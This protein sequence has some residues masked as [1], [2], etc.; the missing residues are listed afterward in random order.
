MSMGPIR[1][2]G[3][4]TTA[5]GPCR[6]GC[7]TDE[8]WRL[9][10]L[11]RT[12]RTLIDWEMGDAVPRTLADELDIDLDTM[13]AMVGS[14]DRKGELIQTIRTLIEWEITGVSAQ[15]KA[16]MMEKALEAWSFDDEDD[17]F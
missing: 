11:V 16:E 4:G 2:E 1:C 12:V 7:P 14:V 15:K 8:L 10:D 9:R 5:G 17:D 6:P 13:K 3:C